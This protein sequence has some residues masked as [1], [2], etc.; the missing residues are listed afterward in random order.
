MSTFLFD[1][2][3]FGPVQ[4]RRLGVS[5]GI[6][7]LPTSRK[8]CNFD[9]VYCECGL[10]SDY[11]SQE[12][13]PATSKVVTLLENKLQEMLLENK[14]PDV[15]TFAGNGEP[16][17]HPDFGI[18]IEHTLRLRNQYFPNAKISVLTNATMLHKPDVIKALKTVDQ[19]LMKLDAGLENTASVLNQPVGKWNLETIINQL[20]TF[21]GKFIFQTMFVHGWVNGKSI[22]NTLEDNLI[23]WTN[24]V[25]ETKPEKVMIY[26][27]ERDT[28]YDGIQRVSLRELEIIAERIESLGI[29]ASVYGR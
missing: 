15:I 19:C 25:K 12:Q 4:S 5:L 27:I 7:L 28:P 8:I 14:A 10:N 9:C 16:T 1:Q 6:N 23:A 13:M 26:S 2:T 29:E 3:I 20:K 11:K 17:L 24:A 21:N 18:I 22:D